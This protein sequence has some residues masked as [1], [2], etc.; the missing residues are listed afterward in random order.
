M[1]KE[2]N[3]ENE[4]PDNRQTRQ[5][6]YTDLEISCEI[7]S[8]EWDRYIFLTALQE[9]RTLYKIEIYAFCVL[10]DRVRLLAGG[11]DVRGQ[12]VRRMLITLFERFERGCELIGEYDV[13]PAGTTTRMTIVPVRDEKDALSILR[14]IHLTPFSEGYVINYTDYWWTSS[15]T[16]REHYTWPMVDPEAVLKYMNRHFPNPK[17]FL[18]E[19]HRRGMALGNPEPSCIRARLHE[20]L[21]YACDKKENLNETFMA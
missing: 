4:E 15:N 21:L 2:M 11:K 16:Y 7:L 5:I 17:Q 3:I 18:S 20:T 9:V 13:I 6:Y 19:Y 14:Y 12:T 10:S 8:N 1:K